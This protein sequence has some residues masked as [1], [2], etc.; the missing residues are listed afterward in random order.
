MRIG[1]VGL[2][3]SGKTTVFNALTQGDAATT[4]YSSGAMDVNTSTVD[5]PDPQLDTLAE[6]YKPKKITHAKV[7]YSDIG[8]LQGDT[9]GGVSITGEHLSLIATNDALIHV[10][11]AFEDENI[12]H[13]LDSLDP[14]RDIQLLDDEF[15]V[16]DL[17]KIENRLPKLE[18]NLKRG[19]LLPS[20]ETEQQEYKLL[21][22]IKEALEN[23]SPIRD[24]DLT[25]AEQK[26]IRGFQFLTEKPLMILINLGDEGAFGLNQL[27][28]PHQH[29]LVSSI[30]GRL[31]M[32]LVNLDGEDLE[33]FMEAFNIRELSLNRIIS[34]SYSLLARM[35]FLTA[36]EQEVRAWEVPQNSSA[37]ECAG[38]IHS[39]LARGFIRAEVM[40][41]TDLI[42]AGSEAALKSAGKYRLEGKEYIVKAGDILLIRF[43]V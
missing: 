11:R 22:K 23:N 8:G 39:D 1:L 30:R 2:P 24:L 38:A 3:N 35:T 43:N 10:V 21:L 40:A 34:E 27:D 20:F 13:P 32:D 41:Y 19:K 6:M 15:L 4:A 36:G 37:V 29:S 5:I 9:D 14:K 16:S 7:E 26:R 18:T 42:E 25:T 17:S 12:P 28:Y 31:E 33:I